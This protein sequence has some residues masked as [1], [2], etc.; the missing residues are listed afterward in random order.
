MEIKMNF[1]RK[2][3]AEL[4]K[5]LKINENFGIVRRVFTVSGKAEASLYFIE[6]FIK[7][8]VTEKILE[9]CVSSD[10]PSDC[11]Y[12]L[13]YTGVSIMSDVEELSD[14]LLHGESILMVDGVETAAVIDV[15]QYPARSVEEPENDR[16]LRGPRDGFGEVLVSNM[17]LIRRRIRDN[18][19]MMNKI[20]IGKST[21][22]DIVICYMENL[23]DKLLVKK[24]EDKLNSMADIGS[25]NMV[26]ESLAEALIHRGWYNPFPKVRYSE[27][28]DAVSSMLLEGSIAIICDNTP[29]IMIIPTSIFEFM[30]ESDDFY[31]PPLIGTYL[32][33]M[34]MLIFMMSLLLTPVWYLL[35]THPES[36]PP[37]LSFIQ[38]SKPAE[39]PLLAQF[40]LIE[41]MIDGLKLASLNTPSMLNNSLSVVGGLILG[42]FAVQTGWFC[43]EVILYMAIVAIASFTQQSYELGYAFKFSRILLLIGSAAFGLWGFIGILLLMVVFIASNKTVSGKGYLYPLIPFDGKALF[44]MFFR[45]R[46]NK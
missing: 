39:V 35:V 21:R 26:Q 30:Q 16:V 5:K 8:S 34:R 17:A 32:R 27:R 44:L 41:F 3:T 46:R 14:C 1:Y 20:T 29:Q 19:L 42:D 6:G 11:I 18:R 45:V 9:F 7:E 4:D 25:M 31:L 2:T 33:I 37:W 40:L 10:S 36:I 23:A 15:R 28:P 38:I 43:P 24:I 13:P 22:N 12:N